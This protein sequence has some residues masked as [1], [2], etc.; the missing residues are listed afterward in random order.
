MTQQHESFPHGKDE[1]EW[2]SVCCDWP[3][4]EELGGRCSKCKDGTG[5]EC[6]CGEAKR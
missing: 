4:Q 5:F 6:D 2:T 3:Y 1:H